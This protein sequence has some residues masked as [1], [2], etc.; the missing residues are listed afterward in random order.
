VNHVSD[1]DWFAIRQAARRRDWNDVAARA[2]ALGWPLL[3]KQ[4][5][6]A[7]WSHDAVLTIIYSLLLDQPDGPDPFAD[8]A[9]DA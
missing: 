6:R 3:A 1:R 9:S 4:A 2:T 8:E 5:R 7:A